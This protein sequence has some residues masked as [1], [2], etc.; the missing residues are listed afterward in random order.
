V[1]A[2]RLNLVTTYGPVPT[3]SCSSSGLFLAAGLIRIMLMRESRMGM[4]FLDSIRNVLSSTGTT[5]GNSGKNPA[6]K[7]PC[8]CW[9]IFSA[10][11]MSS[12]AT[13]VPSE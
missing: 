1:P 10:V 11:A 12:M 7:E 8:T 6:T 5:V 2:P 9:Y 13:G 3:P 4:G